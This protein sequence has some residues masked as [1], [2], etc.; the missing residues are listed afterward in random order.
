M[1]CDIRY[2]TTLK[3]PQ[4]VA[5]TDGV[6]KICL[7]NYKRND[8]LCCHTSPTEANFRCLC[9]DLKNKHNCHAHHFI[10]IV[11]EH[12]AIFSITYKIYLQ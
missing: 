9:R 4:F 8:S 11:S 7:G 5:L 10:Y 12:R 6:H 3:F 1:G 2:P